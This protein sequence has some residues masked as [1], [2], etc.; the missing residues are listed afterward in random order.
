[1]ILIPTPLSNIK[2]WNLAIWDNTDGPGG[3][4]TSEISQSK[5]NTIWFHLYVEQ[6]QTHK[7]GEQTDGCQ[8]GG[9][10]RMNEK[11]EEE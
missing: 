3:Y 8:E 4:Y 7:Y 9:G 6:K 5:T 10:G 11:G 2:E 1:M